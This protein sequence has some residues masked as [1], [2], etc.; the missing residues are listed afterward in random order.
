M[1]YAVAC[2]RG[3][4]MYDVKLN[5]SLFTAMTDERVLPTTV[6]SILAD[7]ARDAP[8]LPALKEA[9]PD[10]SIGRAWT[11]AELHRDAT[12]LATALLSRFQ[13]GERI[14]VYAPNIPEWVLLE[15]AAAMAG[16]VLVTVNPAYQPKELNYVVEQ[17]RSA[18][19]FYVESFR[20]NAMGDHARGAKAAIPAL[21]HLINLE[22]QDDLF[23]GAG[24]RKLPDV[25][26]EDAVQ[27]QY[28]SG[29]TG[30]PKGAV[31]H[32]K[33]LT[34]NARFALG[35]LGVKHGDTYL[36]VMPLFHTGGC[37]IGVLGAV[38]M[39]ACTL[40]VKMF[41]PATINLMVER[42]KVMAFLGVPTMLVGMLEAH[43]T[44]K[45]DMSSLKTVMSGG[46]MVAPEL[47]RA[48]KDAFG[49]TLC[50]IYGQTE[51]SPGITQTRATDSFED[52]TQTIG[53]PYPQTDVAIMDSA[54]GRIMP[55]GETGEICA[56]GYCVMTEY[57][58]NPKATAAAIDAQGW[59]HTG[60]L[61]TMDERGFIKI[62]GRLKDMIIR[63]GENLFPA[64]IENVLLTHPSIAEAAVVG[65]ADP[66]WGELPVAFLR[67]HEGASVS[68]TEL[69]AHVRKELA[70]PKTPAHWY[71]VNSW[72][73][74]GSGK[75]QKFVLRDQHA[76]GAFEGSEI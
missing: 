52:R 66:K 16:L 57:N 17:S 11:Y 26:P 12:H 15:F 33:G 1:L 36:G 73:L 22:S 20:G 29:T 38:Q 56:R 53:Q 6:G 64:E 34:N 27:I 14:A 72:P 19:L 45:R 32:H 60:D 4:S 51:A 69:V 58:D 13:P 59:L 5:S 76:A 65:V 55:L 54:T 8:R 30:F 75:I 49:T 42:E 23:A 47:V 7:A 46:A 70:A 68:R 10:G 40:L 41:D 3:D 39:R 44:H 31:L 18:G 21:R 74:T 25:K 62:T 37:A 67:L 28:T 63:G 50:I 61:G 71:R 2:I 43:R 48:V 9:L 24:T 35:R